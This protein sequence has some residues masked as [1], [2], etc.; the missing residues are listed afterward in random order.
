MRVHERRHPFRIGLGVLAERPADALAKKELR[1]ADGRTD[2]VGEQLR[3]R[4]LLRAELRENGGPPL[5]DVAVLRPFA[6]DRLHRA[7]MSGEHGPHPPAGNRVHVVPPGAG[8][9]HLLDHGKARRLEPARIAPE[10]Q[11]LDRRVAF[12]AVGGP[13]P[14][15]ENGRLPGVGVR[16]RVPREHG[17]RDA[18]A[19]RHAHPQVGHVRLHV[20]LLLRCPGR[21]GGIAQGGNDG[22]SNVHPPTGSTPSSAPAP[23]RAAW[24]LAVVQQMP[25]EDA[26]IDGDQGVDSSSASCSES[27]SLTAR[28]PAT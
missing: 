8:D 9:H 16:Q 13:A 4:P 18:T 27:S 3:V 28:S 12:L 17:A 6:E 14:E 21:V 5:P 24:A 20:C 25:E 11:Q 10:E 22:F 19:L 26:G 7:G 2:R 15:V 23:A 1:V